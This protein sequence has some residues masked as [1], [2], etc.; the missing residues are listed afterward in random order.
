MEQRVFKVV[1]YFILCLLP[2]TAQAQHVWQPTFQLPLEGATASIRHDITL[3][4]YL[5]RNVSI[6]NFTSP[7]ESQFSVFHFLVNAKGSIDSIYVEGDL[8][9]ERVDIIKQNIY[10]TSNK[11]NM[12]QGTTSLNNCWFSFP[13]F[14]AKG[15]PCSENERRYR[16]Q[17]RNAFE[18]YNGSKSTID[19]PGRVILP[20]YSNEVSY[21]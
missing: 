18:L 15:N 10:A 17:L 16:M 13:Y 5:S 9:A 14:F 1:Q 3:S 6:G 2:W 8:N 12:P 4:E 21:K 11:W 20:S 7:C 19:N